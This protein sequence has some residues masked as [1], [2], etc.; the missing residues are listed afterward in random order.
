MIDINDSEFL[1][2]IESKE[3]LDKVCDGKAAAAMIQPGDI[4]ESADSHRAAIRKSRCMNWL[5][6]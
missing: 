2:R 5:N 3:L 6:A 1:S 4:W